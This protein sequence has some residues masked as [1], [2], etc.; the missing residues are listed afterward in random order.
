MSNDV[1][2][3]KERDN[4]TINIYRDEITVDDNPR[5]W[6]N[7]AVFVIN[8]PGHDLGDR[9][10]IEGTVNE[11]FD[12]Y[13]SSKE[14]ID[15]FV[16]EL[17]ATKFT[18]DDGWGYEFDMIDR[19]GNKIHD[20]VGFFNSWSEDEVASELSYGYFSTRKKLSMLEDSNKVA[21]L[22]ISL[23]DHSG[24]TIWLGTTEGYVDARWDCSSVG[25]AY[26][27][28]NEERDGNKEDWKQDAYDIMEKEMKLYDDYVT[29]EVYDWEIRDENDVWVDGCGGYYGSDNFD[30][31]ISEADGIVDKIIDMA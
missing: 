9:Q 18:D 12:K 31:M 5:T 26:V 8:Y 19:H 23:Y 24:V 10:D 30:D 21:I 14:V 16:K 15:T 20:S 4:Y 25:F 27:E 22:P 13:I 7:E 28:Y 11:L 1:V 29:G 3:T 17:K 6:D 2:K